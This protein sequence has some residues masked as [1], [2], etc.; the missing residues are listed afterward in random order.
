M[1]QD[2]EQADLPQLLESLLFVSDGPLE[3]RR[4]QQLLE[5]GR[6]PLEQAIEGL[7]QQY[8]SR[9]LRLQRQGEMLQLVTAPACSPYVEKLLGVQGGSKLSPAALETLAIV[10]YEQPVTRA[11]IEAIRGVNCDRALATLQARD[12]VCEVGRLET[13]GRPLLF[14]TTFEFMQYFGLESIDQLPPLN[15]NPDGPS[16]EIKQKT[17]QSK[18]DTR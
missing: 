10:A 18:D 3:V 12:L 15:T 14:G 7:T 9:G 6:E 4:L 11:R 5:V 17:S 16:D 8:R 2:G 1:E 13:L